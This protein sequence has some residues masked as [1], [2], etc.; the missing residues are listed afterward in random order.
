MI[1][2]YSQFCLNCLLSLR[3]IQ[4]STATQNTAQVKAVVEFLGRSSLWEKPQQKVISQRTFLVLHLRG[5]RGKAMSNSFRKIRSLISLTFSLSQQL[6]PHTAGDSDTLGCCCA[7]ALES[8]SGTLSSLPVVIVQGDRRLRFMRSEE[9]CEAGDPRLL[10]DHY[11]FMVDDA[12]ERFC[13]EYFFSSDDR[14]LA[15]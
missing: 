12:N 2:I 9:H 6:S 5:Y 4:Y 13:Q 8:A 1:N 14:K 15:Y 11:S 7:A 10:G 3:T